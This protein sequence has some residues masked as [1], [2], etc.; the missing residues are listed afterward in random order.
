MACIFAPNCA[1]HVTASCTFWFVVGSAMT[2]GVY[3]KRVLYVAAYVL[4]SLPLMSLMGTFL[5]PRQSTSDCAVALADAD[6]VVEE[7]V[8]VD[9]VLVEEVELDLVL[10]EEVELDLVLVEAVELLELL[11][12]LPHVPKLGW[13]PVPQYAVPVPHQPGLSGR[14]V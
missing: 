5:M 11:E 3:I 1:P 2:E 4:Q 9:L 8:E 12:E 7:E 6:D 13:Q 10:V 14:V